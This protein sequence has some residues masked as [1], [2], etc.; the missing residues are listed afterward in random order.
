MQRDILSVPWFNRLDEYYGA[1]LIEPS[2]F[3]L[4]WE[5]FQKFD[6]SAHMA[7]QQPARVSSLELLPGKGG[8]QVALVKAAGLLMKQQSSMGG[9]STVQLRRDIRQ[10]ANNPEVSGILLAIDSPG[11]T[12]AGTSDLASE[13]KAARRQKP[14]WAYIEDLGAS[15]AYW[16]ASQADMVF[17]N[18]PTALVGSIGTI[19]TIYDASAAAEQA[20][21]KTL[22]FSTGPLKGTGTPGASVTDEQQQYLQ[23]LVDGIQETFDGAVRSGRG[24]NASQ[25]AAVRSGAVFPA[26]QAM[27]LKL[28]DG[29]RSLD[30]TLEALANAK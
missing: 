6:F 14:V 26:A 4:Q 1:W 10:A 30:K 24:L 17:A 8:K 13:V 23:S 18:S 22:V 11:G 29:I 7:A 2:R 9:T 5:L 3:R 28:I 25:L 15:A 19:Q 27:E 20:G 21:I 16:T 12:A